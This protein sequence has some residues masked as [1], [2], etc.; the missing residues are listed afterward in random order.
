MTSTKN[1][2]GKKTIVAVETLVTPTSIHWVSLAFAAVLIAYINKNYWF[3]LDELAITPPHGP[4]YTR[5]RSGMR[6][7]FIKSK[8]KKSK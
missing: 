1:I 7:I 8:Y 2:R 6:K 3:I 4:T 5:L